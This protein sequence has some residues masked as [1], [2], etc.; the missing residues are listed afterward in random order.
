MTAAI[1]THDTFTLLLAIC[2][3]GDVAALLQLIDQHPKIVRT[4]VA[5]KSASDP[6]SSP[7]RVAAARDFLAIVQM[8][9]NEGA[10]IPEQVNKLVV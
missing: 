7:I 3:S 1:T 10:I 4:L 5:D 8:L 6:D 2:E 9:L